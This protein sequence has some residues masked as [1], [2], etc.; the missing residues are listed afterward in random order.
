MTKKPI[1]I[2]GI[3]LIIFLVIISSN[4]TEELRRGMQ[5]IKKESMIERKEKEKP[6]SMK[7]KA[8]IVLSEQEINIKGEEKPTIASEIFFSFNNQIL[9]TAPSG[10]N[11]KNQNSTKP[12]IGHK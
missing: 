3:F 10:I 11:F 5:E 12:H 2:I 7:E 8:E 1:I 6:L 9:H 4:K